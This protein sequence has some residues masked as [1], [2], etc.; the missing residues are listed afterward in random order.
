MSGDAARRTPLYERHVAYG[1]KIVEFAG[2]LMPIQY[3]SIIAEHKRVRSSVGIFDVS[4]MGRVEIRGKDA[5]QFVNK[6]TINDASQLELY[7]A[8]YTAFCYPSGGLVDDLLVYRLPSHYLLVI[9]AANAAKDLDWLHSNRTGDVQIIDRTARTA[10]IAVQGPEAEAVIQ[11]LTTV[12]LSEVKF[13]WSL[14]GRLRRSLSKPPDIDAIISRTGYTGEDGFEL[15]FDAE[16]A[17]DVWNAVLEAGRRFEIAPVGLAARDSLRLE[18][19]Y[20]LYGNDISQDTTPLE[21]GLSWITKLNKGDFIGR[22]AL[23]KQK[24]EGARRK[25]VGFEMEGK[26]FPRHGYA[27]FVGTQRVGEVTSGVFSPSLSKGIGMGYVESPHAVIGAEIEVDVRGKHEKA[28]VVSRPFY[29]Q[30]SRK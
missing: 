24:E 3:E 8:Q 11:R 7:R 6:M 22:D 13:Y 12:P 1:A 30:G 23:L 9:N 15:Y 29:K 26:A 5:L 4:H 28:R 19:G 16:A 10:E 2:F 14:P 18:M 20:C 17:V 21:A 27:I 25:L